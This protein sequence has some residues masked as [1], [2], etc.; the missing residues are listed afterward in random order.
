VPS[1]LIWLVTALQGPIFVS[2]YCDKL[3]HFMSATVS[4]EILLCLA[5]RMAY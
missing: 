2:G 5:T 4:T 3:N 1:E